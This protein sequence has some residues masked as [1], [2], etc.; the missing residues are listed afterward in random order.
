VVGIDGRYLLKT[1]NSDYDGPNIGLDRFYLYE[2]PSNAATTCVKDRCSVTFR[3]GLKSG[4]SKRYTLKADPEREGT[5]VGTSSGQID[6]PPGTGGRNI[7][8]SERI[9][10]RAG[11][12]TKIGERQVAGRLSLYATLTARCDDPAK[13][14]ATLRGPRQP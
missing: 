11:S 10:V 4:G 8:S 2:E 5:Y 13:Y 6:C 1:V 14:V 7:P 12:V 3:L 9:A